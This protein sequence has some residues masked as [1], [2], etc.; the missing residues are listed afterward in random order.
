LVHDSSQKDWGDV[1]SISLFTEVE[2]EGY[3]ILF[4]DF[5]LKVDTVQKQVNP[6]EDCLPR[7]DSEVGK[8]DRTRHFT[9]SASIAI[10]TLGARG[11]K[12][13]QNR[14]VALCSRMKKKQA[15]GP[16]RSSEKSCGETSISLTTE[17]SCLGSV[18]TAPQA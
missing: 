12:E 3:Q 2:L 9:S 6:V 15:G 10:L 1:S 4:V 18:P 5:F 13:S 8:K 16:V 7:M 11:V 17:T 14:E